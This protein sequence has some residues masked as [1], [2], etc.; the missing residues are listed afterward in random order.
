MKANSADANA[1][2]TNTFTRTTT[3]TNNNNATSTP[4]N[5]SRL[6]DSTAEEVDI[7][8]NRI[9]NAIDTREVDVDT[10]PLDDNFKTGD[11]LIDSDLYDVTVCTRQKNDVDD[12]HA[13]LPCIYDDASYADVFTHLLP[14]D[15][16]K[17][18]LIPATNDSLR[19]VEQW[20]TNTDAHFYASSKV[21]IDETMMSWDNP[22][23]YSQ[24]HCPRKPKDND[25]EWKTIACCE[26]NI[27]LRVDLCEDSL[28]AEA[29]V[30]RRAVHSGH[31]HEINGRH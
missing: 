9:Q 21:C 7:G 24:I 2:T 22:L 3:N 14:M 5:A 17:N 20:N 25:N 4:H 16:V 12:F 28:P 6:V 11:V 23:G 8:T 10:R 30:F 31:R 13:K 29:T 27:I 19:K 15:W 18:T 26:T 1:D